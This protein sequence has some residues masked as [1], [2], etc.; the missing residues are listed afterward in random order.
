MPQK[1]L[2][3]LPKKPHD[4]RLKLT[5]AFRERG[6]N[7]SNRRRGS[8]LKLHIDNSNFRNST[9]LNKW[10]DGQKKWLG[11]H[12]KPG[13]ELMK[14][15]EQHKWNDK[16]GMLMSGTCLEWIRAGNSIDGRRI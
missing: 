1:L 3:A 6:M 15:F 16:S 9:P 7:D 12:P 4:G 5:T 8:P 14:P 13:V 2:A 11:K 10:P